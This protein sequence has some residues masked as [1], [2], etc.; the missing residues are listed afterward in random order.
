[1]RGAGGTPGGLGQFFLGFIMMCVGFY[2]L[3]NAISVHSSFG[4]GTRLY[5]LNFGGSQWPITSGMVLVPFMFG[6][7]LVFYNARNIIGWLLT[8]G[9]LAALIFG[10]IISLQFSLRSMSAFELLMVL[11]L[12]LGGLGLFLR[13]LR[14]LPAA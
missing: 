6:I 5:H 12:A 1:M 10:V 2:W 11:V 14:N 13:S 3:L 7:A 8:L 4:F 9:S